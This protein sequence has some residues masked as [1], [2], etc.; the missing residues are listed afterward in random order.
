M[1]DTSGRIEFDGFLLGGVSIDLSDADELAEEHV[2]EFDLEAIDA[3]A[4][5]AVTRQAAHLQIDQC[6]P[7]SRNDRNQIGTVATPTS[8]ATALG[9]TRPLSSNNQPQPTSQL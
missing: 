5:A 8:I 3:D 7:A 9:N 1:P 4:A 6:L 2:K